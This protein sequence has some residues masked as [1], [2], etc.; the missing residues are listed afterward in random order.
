MTT[1]ITRLYSDSSAAA[2]AKASL[3]GYGLDEDVIHIITADVSGGAAAAMKAARVTAESAKAYHAAMTGGQALLV[4]QA[5]FN[6][7]GTARAAIKVLR[8]HPALNVGLEDE[9]VYLREY[10]DARHA[11][12]IM[13]G[14][15]LLM[16]NS[17]SRPSH[18]HILGSNPIMESKTRTSAM[19]GGGYMSKMFWPMKLVSAPKQGTSAIRG[20]KLF[21]SMFGLPL[22]TQTWTSRE[23][24]PTIIR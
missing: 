7:V 16:S 9:D 15:P 21:S 4:V 23:D 18:G 1:I 19:R 14:G 12:S 5:P 20:G 22:L 17:F 3:L 11:N 13:K 10:P 24:Y 2:A 8:K 6:P